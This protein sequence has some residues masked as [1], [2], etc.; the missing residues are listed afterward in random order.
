VGNGA[1]ASQMAVILFEKALE[2]RAG[3]KS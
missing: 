3:K 1:L 2:Q